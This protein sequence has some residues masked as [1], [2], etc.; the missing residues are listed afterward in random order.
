MKEFKLVKQRAKNEILIKP[1]KDDNWF[2][3]IIHIERKSGKEVSKTMII[4]KDLDQFLINYQNKGWIKEE[5]EEKVKKT[6]K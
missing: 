3:Y 6:K 2:L 5:K 4:E 1:D